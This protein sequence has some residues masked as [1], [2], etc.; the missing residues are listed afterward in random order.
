MEYDQK[1]LDECI[2]EADRYRMAEWDDD[3]NLI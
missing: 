1:T 2:K 3:A